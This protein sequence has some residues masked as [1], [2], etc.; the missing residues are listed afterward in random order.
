ML[1]PNNTC[2]T[3]WSSSRRT[4]R[5]YTST[6]LKLDATNSDVTPSD[7]LNDRSA[8]HP[9]RP[10]GPTAISSPT[11]SSTPTRVAQQY[12]P[13]QAER[14]RTPYPVGCPGRGY[15][16]RVR[17]VRQLRLCGGNAADRDLTGSEPSR[18]ERE[19]WQ[20]KGMRNACARTARRIAAVAV[21]A[22][23]G[24]CAREETLGPQRGGEPR[25]P[26]RRQRQRQRRRRWSVVSAGGGQPLNCDAARCTC[27]NIAS[28]GQ[29][30]HYGDT[31]EFTDWLNSKSTA[32]V[33]MY[34]T[35]P[36]LTADFLSKYNVL[37]IQ[38]LTDSKDRPVL[39]VH[40]RRGRSAEGVGQH[41]RRAPSRCP[42]TTP[43][44]RKSSR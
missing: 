23:L 16:V 26:E 3:T 37:L 10:S 33:D 11:R 25:R 19:M 12:P 9:R 44:R 15:G 41:G 4:T 8:G 7:G 6:R 14:R 24:G 17:F 22:S 30:G 27:I 21:V 43:I 40:R 36:T 20:V 32:A 38:W 18:A 29:P 35:H 39:D 13:G 28:I 2:S 34:T 42:G 31:T 1:T 5:R